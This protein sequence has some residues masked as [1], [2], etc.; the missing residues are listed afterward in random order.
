MKYMELKHKIINQCNPDFA[1]PF[2]TSYKDIFSTMLEIKSNIEQSL[3]LSPI[4]LKKSRPSLANYLYFQSDHQLTLNGVMQY[5][6][7]YIK[8]LFHKLFSYSF[9]N[10]SHGSKKQGEG[11]VGSLFIIHFFFFICKYSYC[12]STPLM[13]PVQLN[14]KWIQNF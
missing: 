14:M 10:F 8:L 9:F 4:T 2:Y 5:I 1:F 13:I 3:L 6:Y 11:S 7:V 12:K